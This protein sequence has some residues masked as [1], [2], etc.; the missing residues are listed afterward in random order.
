MEG[1]RGV[2][3]ITVRTKGNDN[4]T[5]LRMDIVACRKCPRLV[6]F[7]EGIAAQKTKRFS[8][9]DYWGRP[10]PGFGDRNASIVIVGLAP[11]AHGGN[12]TGRV[13]TG[14]LSAKFLI[15]CLCEVGLTNQPNSD[16]MED[17]LRMIDS[18]MLAAVRCVPPDNRPTREEAENC[19]PFLDRELRL[20]RN[21]RAVLLLG[22]FAF[23]SYVR[24][25]NTISGQ[26]RRKMNFAHGAVYHV[27][28][29]PTIYS[30]YH[31]SPRNTNTGTLTRSMFID[32]LKKL[33]KD[34][35][36]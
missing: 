1:Q 25:V 26:R 18:Y 8:D 13:F 3:A 9:W 16:S 12:R 34:V 4:L 5:K 2:I 33:K 7:R 35:H 22:K 15:D 36:S 27:D 6:E 24:F 19:F 32:L 10:V 30:S 28:G 29:F 14:D 31:P 20:L 23:D 11:A 17:G 21:A